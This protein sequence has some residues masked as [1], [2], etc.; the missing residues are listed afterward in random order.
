MGMSLNR[1]NHVVSAINGVKKTW[2][3]NRGSFDRWVLWC[4]ARSVLGVSDSMGLSDEDTRKALMIAGL[5]GC[6]LRHIHLLQ[7]KWE[8]AKQNALGFHHGLP[9][10]L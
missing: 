8:D 2:E 7:R 5:I 1:I 3:V 6:L 9:L 10:Q 4:D